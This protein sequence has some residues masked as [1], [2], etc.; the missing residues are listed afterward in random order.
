MDMMIILAIVIG[1]A[2]G[3]ALD[4]VGATNPGYIIGMLNLSKLHLMRTILTAIGV[5]SI[6][7]FGGLLLGLVEPGHL[8]V[9]TLYS[10]VFIGGLLL[11]A[12]FAVAGYCPGTG[13]CAAA[14]GR[15]DALVF[16]VGGRLMANAMSDDPAVIELATLL[17]LMVAILQISGGVQDVALGAL[18]GM[19][20]NT[21]PSVLTLIAY[22]PIALPASYLFGFVLGY[23]APGVWVGYTLGLTLTAIALPWRFW[24]LTG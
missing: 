6:L 18:R 19:S 9:K 17:F 21:W 8:D 2:F 15:W 10:G 11:G 7:L 13:L 12:G 22:W 1:V 5:A 4:R 16:I 20:D 23:G 24:R 14:T 3:A